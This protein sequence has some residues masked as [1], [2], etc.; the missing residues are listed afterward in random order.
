MRP[1][2]DPLRS[3]FFSAADRAVRQVF[4]DGHQVVKDGEVTTIDHAAMRGALQ[5]S[6]EAFVRNAPYVDY[7]GR[8][9]DE[10]SPTS[11]RIEG[12]N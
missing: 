8:T 2:R 12:R 6:Q 4:V 11:F 7:R 3:F 9:A 10:I 1:V 5:D